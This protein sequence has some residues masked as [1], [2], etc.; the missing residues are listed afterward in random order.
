M[1]SSLGL[2]LAEYARYSPFM[3]CLIGRCSRRWSLGV[4]D[5]EI[6]DA[7]HRNVKIPDALYD[8]EFPLDQE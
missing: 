5:L 8:V 2:S 4:L 1:L 3:F 7:N 6:P